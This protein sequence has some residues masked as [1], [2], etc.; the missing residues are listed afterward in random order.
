M[1]VRE[2]ERTMR[3]KHYPI[4][5]K[6]LE[7]AQASF[8]TCISQ[9]KNKPSCTDITIL[10]IIGLNTTTTQWLLIIGTY[11]NRNEQLN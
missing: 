1:C 3:A 6:V 7:Y 11:N 10:R 2:R 9:C 5:Y 4:I 8:N